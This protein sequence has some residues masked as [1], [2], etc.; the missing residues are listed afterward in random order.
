VTKSES[1]RYAFIP[2]IVAAALASCSG[3]TNNPTVP[4]P[5]S[6]TQIRQPGVQG[7]L[8]GDFLGCPYQTGDVWQTDITSAKV[9]PNSAAYIKAVNDAHGGGNFTAWA[10]TTNELINSASASTPLVNVVG[11]VKWHTPYSPWPWQS[12]FY[13]SPMSDAHALVLQETN[14]QYYEGY[15]VTYSNGTLSMYN[16]GMWDLSKAFVRPAQGS[17][18]TASGIPIGLVA[19]RPEELKAGSIL[20]ALGW[21]GVAHSWSQTAC[22]S[23]AGK[24]DCTDDLSYSGPSGDKPM[25]YGA[26]LRLKASFNDSNFPAEAKT[27]AEALKHYGAYGYDTGCCNAIVFVNDQNGGPTWTSADKTAISSIKLSNFDVVV[28]P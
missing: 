19:V 10:P 22:V 16:G 12:N 15:S 24:T 13:I 4:L 1:P 14:C 25:P 2:F 18:S 5:N 20:H 26:H 11:K 21:D 27:V 17:I 8:N 3:T 23:P 7:S 28:A 6:N 9:D